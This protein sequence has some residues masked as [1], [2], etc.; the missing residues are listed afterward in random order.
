MLRS[1]ALIFAMINLCDDFR[2][3]WDWLEDGTGIQVDLTSTDEFSRHRFLRETRKIR[4]Q[5]LEWDF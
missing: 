4:Q 1:H 3:K 2:I 5:L